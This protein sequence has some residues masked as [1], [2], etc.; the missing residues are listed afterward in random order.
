MREALQKL[1]DVIN[2]YSVQAHKLDHNSQ[3][4]RLTLKNGSVNVSPRLSTNETTVY[5]DAFNEG[6]HHSANNR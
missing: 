2:Y 4:W 6:L 5:L 3:G 1:L